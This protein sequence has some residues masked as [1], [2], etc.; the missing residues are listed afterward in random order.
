MSAYFENG[1][2]IR[3]SGEAGMYEIHGEKE[4]SRSFCPEC[5]T[6]LFWKIPSLAGQTGVAAGCF[7]TNPLPEPKLS[8]SNEGK[9]EWLSLP[10]GWATSAEAG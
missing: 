9:Y 5:G 2:V 4:Q 7:T 6:T 1:Q 10:A 8:V 3:I